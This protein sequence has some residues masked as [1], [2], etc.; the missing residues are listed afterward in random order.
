[1][2]VRPATTADADAIAACQFACWREAYT[3]L[4]GH[5][6]LARRTVDPGARVRLWG[7]I[8]AGADATWIAATADDGVVG[9]VVAGAGRDEGIDL[10]FELKAIYLLA[11]HH[12]SGIADRLVDVAVG[13]ADAYLWVFA[14]NPRARSFYA[15]HRFVADGTVRHDPSFELDEIRMARRKPG[16]GTHTAPGT[17]RPQGRAAHRGGPAS[18]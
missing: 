8:I 6:V 1:M 4:A 15:R 10:P 7:R 2:T 3:R 9:F 16:G 18:S 12:G 11:R 17:P 13:D 14:G 5:A